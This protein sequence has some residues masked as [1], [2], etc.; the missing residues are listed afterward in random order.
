MNITGNQ[1]IL[2]PKYKWTLYGIF[3]IPMGTRGDVELFST[4]SFTDDV[5]F[6][7]ENNPLDKADS[8]YRWDV[9]ANWTAAGENIVVSAFVN[10]ILDEIGVR[11]ISR[12]SEN[13]NYL[14]SATPTDPRLLGLEFTYKFG[15]F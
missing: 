4:V 15:A 9:R 8:Y 1:F 6:S 7:L 14:R 13:Q 2:V 11:Q 5:F 3:N 10:N 12:Y